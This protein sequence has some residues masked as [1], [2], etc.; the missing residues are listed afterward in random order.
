MKALIT[1]FALLSFVAAASIPSAVPAQ[2]QTQ[3]DHAKT[4]HKDKK[5]G[6]GKKHAMK[7]HGHHGKTANKKKHGAPPHKA[8]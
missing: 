4:M 6:H 2:A 3:G 8:G 5:A 1:A 7:G